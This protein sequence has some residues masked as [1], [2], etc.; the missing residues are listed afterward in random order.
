MKKNLFLVCSL[1]TLLTLALNSCNRKEI[2]ESAIIGS[3]TLSSSDY[4][5]DGKLL[6]YHR[7][8]IGI[9]DSAAN[10]PMLFYDYDVTWQFNEEGKGCYS[11]GT[12]YDFTYTLKDGQIN[13]SFGDDDEEESTIES[14]FTLDNGKIRVNDIFHN[15]NG[16]AKADDKENVLGADGKKDHEL[17]AVNYYEKKQ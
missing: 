6:D 7:N 2:K 13:I 5:F 12:S 1:F 11:N 16:W 3:F 8:E 10:K 14:K 17:E 15:I 9:C 4:Y